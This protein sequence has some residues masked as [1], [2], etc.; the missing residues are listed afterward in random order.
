MVMRFAVNCK[1]CYLRWLMLK[2]RLHHCYHFCLSF[3][4]FKMTSHAFIVLW[5]SPMIVMHHACVVH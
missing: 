3:K 5:P 1:K 4:V 2:G